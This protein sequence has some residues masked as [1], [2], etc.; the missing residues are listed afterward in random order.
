MTDLRRRPRPV[1][2]NPPRLRYLGVLTLSFLGYLALLLIRR[3]GVTAYLLA[4]E[5]K[6]VA[7]P[8]P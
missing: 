2:W 7:E 5:W 1:N 3:H 4:W 8:M 6:M